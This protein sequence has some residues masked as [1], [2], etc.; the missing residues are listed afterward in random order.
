MKKE[1]KKL[2]LDDEFGPKDKDDIKGNKM[3]LYNTG[4]APPGYIKP[5]QIEWL[6]PEEFAG[7]DY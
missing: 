6:Y 1:N 2:Y 3:S 5:E 7:E 4:E